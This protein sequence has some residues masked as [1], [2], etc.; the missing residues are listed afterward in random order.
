MRM[1]AMVEEA[2]KQQKLKKIRYGKVNEQRMKSLKRDVSELRMIAVKLSSIKHERMVWKMR[3]EGEVGLSLTLAIHD[4][5][6]MER[7]EDPITIKTRNAC[8]DTVEREVK[9]SHEVVQEE[10]D[11]ANC[12]LGELEQME[13]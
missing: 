6:V 5:N 12:H 3:M 1:R 2:R 13:M 11:L 8:P 7:D 9:R 10:L 4:W